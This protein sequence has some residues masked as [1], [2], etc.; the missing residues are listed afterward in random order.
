MHSHLPHPIFTYTA[1]NLREM[2]DPRRGAVATRPKSDRCETRSRN[3]FRCSEATRENPKINKKYPHS[4]CS[5]SSEFTGDSHEIDEILVS[6]I[7]MEARE[8][9]DDLS[10]TS[11]IASRKSLLV[12]SNFCQPSFTRPRRR[13]YSLRSARTV[14]K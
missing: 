11:M 6:V 3:A 14:R 9:R 4:G 13:S 1:T 10:F 2:A 5:N 7:Y 12:S 8:T